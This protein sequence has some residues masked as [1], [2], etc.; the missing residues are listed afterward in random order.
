VAITPWLINKLARESPSFLLKLYRRIVIMFNPMLIKHGEINKQFTDLSK[1]ELL[2][3]LDILKTKLTNKQ[4]IE[5]FNTSNIFTTD[6]R[7]EYLNKS[8]KEHLETM[9]QYR[10]EQAKE[11]KKIKEIKEAPKENINKVIS[12]T[13][14]KSK[15]DKL[16]DEEVIINEWTTP[17]NYIILQQYD[18]KVYENIEKTIIKENKLNHHIFTPSLLSFTKKYNDRIIKKN[19]IFIDYKDGMDNLY[20]ELY[21]IV[22]NII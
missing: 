18:P 15:N 5:I 22:Q 17:L 6:E 1:D 19:S 16:K 21:N 11:N 7:M 10:K 12:T 9:K 4:A 8:S 14:E 3:K 20:K 13:T 2:K